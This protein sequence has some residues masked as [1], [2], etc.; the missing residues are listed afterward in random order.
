[1]V[2]DIGTADGLVLRSLMEYCRLN[3][4][5][6]IDVE[7]GYL[8]AAKDNVPY[9]V[10]ADGKRLPFCTHSVECIISTS[11]FKH[12]RG[13][14][15]LLKECHR[16][17]KPNGKL[18]ATDPTPL[19]IRLGLRLGHFS[20]RSIVQMLS[21]QDTQR[22]LIQSGFKVVYTGRFMLSPIPFVGCSILEKALK[23]MHFDWLFFNQIV[24][25]QYLT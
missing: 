10:Q 20:K 23:W 18:I 7:F 22:M 1:M 25:A 21:L 15:G 13:L 3:R 4:C 16:V 24:C 8:K 9:V 14:A 2:L 17:L 6:G 11:V 12:I 19:G 5:I